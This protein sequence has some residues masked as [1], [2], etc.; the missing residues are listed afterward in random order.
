MGRVRRG[1]CG[2]VAEQSTAGSVQ[3]EQAFLCLS[4]HRA[5]IAQQ[6]EL[7]SLWLLTACEVTDSDSKNNAGSYPAANSG[8]IK[9]VLLLMINQECAPKLEN[10]TK[11]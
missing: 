1:F 7:L 9:T 6:D 4:D 11:G 8:F 5:W 3:S 2:L 10:I